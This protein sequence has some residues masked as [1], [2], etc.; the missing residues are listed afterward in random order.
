MRA[1]YPAPRL[2]GVPLYDPGDPHVDSPRP[3]NGLR[4]AN[5][6][7]WFGSALSTF[8][9][10]FNKDVV[11]HLGVPEPTTWRDLA[12]RRYRM[13]LALADPTRSSSAK[14]AFMVMVERAMADAS[15]G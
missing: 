1:A 8:G 6:P 5:P 13:W 14:T 10:I 3:S 12:D 9:I 2:G 7:T 15:A 4:L 11:R